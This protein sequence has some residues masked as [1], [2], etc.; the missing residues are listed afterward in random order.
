[1]NQNPQ[2]IKFANEDIRIAADKIA[3][4]YYFAKKLRNFWFANNMGAVFPSAEVVDD[5]ASVDGRPVIDGNK[6]LLMVTR[7]EELINDLEANGN[8]KLNTV[9]SVAVNPQRM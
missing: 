5:G 2:A 6:V 4:A 1:M 3:Q 8:A 7:C 9:L